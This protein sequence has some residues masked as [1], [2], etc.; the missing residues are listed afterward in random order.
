MNDFWLR[1]GVEDKVVGETESGGVCSQTVP[2][3]VTCV[4][5]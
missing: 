5:M 2:M 4:Y 1:D 3:L